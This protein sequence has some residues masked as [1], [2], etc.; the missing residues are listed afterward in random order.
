[1]GWRVALPASIA[2]FFALLCLGLWR[3]EGLS[4]ALLLHAGLMITAWAAVLP[5]GAIVARWMKVTPGQDFPRVLDNKSWWHWH[6]ALQYAGVAMSTLGFAAIVQVSGG[7]FATTHG[8]IGL[9]VVLLGWAQVIAGWLRGSKG[10]PTDRGAD[11]AKPDTWRGDHFD[12]TPRRRLFEA[13]HK[14]GG[15]IAIALSVAAIMTGAALFGGPDWLLLLTCC[16]WL[17]ALVAAARFVRHRRHVDTYV[18]IWG[19]DLR[20]PLLRG[21][22]TTPQPGGSRS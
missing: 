12:M 5:A 10:G 14:A 15:W 8:R 16:A 21:A 4:G 20:S 1:V 11:P 13:I 17:A 9:A 19:P 3:L 7:S 22:T 6:R 2:L 18:A